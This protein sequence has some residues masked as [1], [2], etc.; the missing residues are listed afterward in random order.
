MSVEEIPEVVPAE[1]RAGG[2]GEGAGERSVSTGVG[3]LLHGARLGLRTRD[4][5]PHPRRRTRA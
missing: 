4:T 5:H 1:K 3:T 2:R